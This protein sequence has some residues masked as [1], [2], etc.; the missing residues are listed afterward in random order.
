MQPHGQVLAAPQSCAVRGAGRMSEFCVLV[1]D[2]ESMVRMLVGRALESAG[3]MVVGAGDGAQ[4]LELLER[5]GSGIDL[6]LTDIKMP[7]LGGL[8]LGREI[9]LRQWPVPVVYMSADPHYAALG[10]AADPTFA[11]CLVKPFDMAVLIAMV[12]R[13]L[14][15]RSSSRASTCT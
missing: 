11:P 4:A 1:V 2:D 7:R 8:E 10:G 13:M 12:A 14:T 15:G 5:A 6:V 3:Y 9:A